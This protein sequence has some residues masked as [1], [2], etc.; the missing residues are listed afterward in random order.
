MNRAEFMRQLESLL[1]NISLTERQEAL[2][3]YNDYFDDAG[4]ENEQAVIEALGTPARVAEN[5]KR[6]LYGAGY[7]AEEYHRSP[8]KGRE[9]GTYRGDACSGASASPAGETAGGKKKLSPG[10]I[11]LIVI[12]CILASPVLLGVA[13]GILGVA[14]SAL[15]TVAGLILGWF[16]LIAGFGV[17]AVVLI[18]LMLLFLGLGFGSLYYSP[19]IGMMLLGGGLICGGVGIL[20][21]MLTVA[22]AGIITPAVFHG[23]ERLWRHFFPE[24]K[25]A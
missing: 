18:L 6:D 5:I 23:L 8:V 13:G 10:W 4:A 3:Y 19:W 21:L 11:A 22:M 1:Q 17:A 16:G 24:R 9:L 14:L 2:Q 12:L 15:G 20:F 7:G 25:K